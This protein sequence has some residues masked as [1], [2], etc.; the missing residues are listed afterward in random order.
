M[1]LLLGLARDYRQHLQQSQK[2]QISLHLRC[3][4]NYSTKQFILYL[5]PISESFLALEPS[6]RWIKYYMDCRAHS[7]MIYSSNIKK[8]PTKLL[9]LRVQCAKLFHLKAISPHEPC[10]WISRNFQRKQ[11]RV[12]MS[13]N[14]LQPLAHM[15]LIKNTHKTCSSFSKSEITSIS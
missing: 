2:S 4:K 1:I 5:G 9:A 10:H 12:F 15:C 13:L 8:S 3:E 7:N 14:L 6:Q 11:Q